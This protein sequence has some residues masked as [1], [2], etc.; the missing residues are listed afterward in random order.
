MRLRTPVLVRYAD[1]MVLCCYS[2]QQ[3]EQVKARLADGW[4]RGVWSSTRTRRRSCTST[5]AS[6]SSGSM[7]VAIDRRQAADQAEQ[8]C[9][10][11]VRVGSPTRCAVLRGSNAMA[12]IARFN[13][14]IRGGPPTTGGWCPASHSH[15]L[16][17]Y[18]WWL[19]FRW[20]RHT[21]PRKSKKWIVRRY[22]GGFNRFRND[23]WVFGD[24]APA[25]RRHRLPDQIRLDRHRPAPD[26]SRAG[27]S[28]RPRPDRLLGHAAAKELNHRWTATT[29]ACSPSRTAAARCAATPALRRPSRRSP[30]SDWE[31]LV[32]DGSSA[33]RSPPDDQVP[34]ETTWARQDGDPTASYTPSCHRSARAR[35]RRSTGET[36]LTADGTRLSRVRRRV[37][38]TVLREDRRSNAAVLPN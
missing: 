12:V 23:R 21:H 18:M 8:G 3:A 27:V 15:S 13:P 4:R 30:L 37:A 25:S 17:D 20:A 33:G 7:S 11:A 6:T 16:D 5:R 34:H 1:D 36:P 32:A 9:G 29:C 14:I 2:R 35:L 26:W 10:Q 31:R 28:G 24:P 22:F 38:R 19:T